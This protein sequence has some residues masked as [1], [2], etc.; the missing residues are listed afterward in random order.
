MA[1][2]DWFTYEF[3]R[4]AA[5]PAKIEDQLQRLRKTDPEIYERLGEALIAIDGGRKPDWLGAAPIRHS[6]EVGELQDYRFDRLIFTLWRSPLPNRY[7]L[8]G[9]Y[10]VPEF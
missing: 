1:Q 8:V 3:R 10:E 4:I 6:A 9:F 2:D 7:R 5:P